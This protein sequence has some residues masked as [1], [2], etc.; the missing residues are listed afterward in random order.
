MRHLN[1]IIN[2]INSLRSK[3]LLH[4]AAE[5]DRFL[6]RNA[7]EL[8]GGN[9]LADLLDADPTGGE[10]P[11][12]GETPEVPAPEQA[13]QTPEASKAICTLYYQYEKW[14]AILDRELPKFDYFGKEN[15]GA[16]RSSLSNVHKAFDRALQ[17]K[18][19]NFDKQQVD[20]WNQEVDKIV[21]QMKQSQ[22]AK[23]DP[24]KAIVDAN[25]LYNTT[26]RLSES[27]KRI[28]GSEP[29]LNEI[30]QEFSNLMHVFTNII[31]ST[32]EQVAGQDLTKVR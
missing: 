28:A 32:S 22:Q 11:P 26:N 10:A 6:R 25:L 12:E 31:K 16:L 23:L 24:T 18:P 4:H 30:V 29:G 2:V 7:Q 19:R 8:G 9:P 27:C 3:G 15:I 20:R 14:H 17:N 5:L 1:S 21:Q 13:P